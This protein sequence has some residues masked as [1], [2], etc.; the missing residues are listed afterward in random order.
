LKKVLRLLGYV[1]PYWLQAFFVG[2]P[3]GGRWAF[4]DAFRLLLVVLS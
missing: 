3:D 1:Q 4:L 2:H